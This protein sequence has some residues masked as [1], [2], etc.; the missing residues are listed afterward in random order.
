[1][2]H[3][4][5][6]ATIFRF[7]GYGGLSRT[8]ETTQ[9]VTRPNPSQTGTSETESRYREKLSRSDVS[10]IGYLDGSQ[11]VWIAADSRVDATVRVLETALAGVLRIRGT[12]PKYLFSTVTI[13]PEPVL[14]EVE[15]E[16][17]RKRIKLLQIENID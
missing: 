16:R 3:L 9:S 12:G 17:N 14:G 5:E 7:T 13:V 15:L 1:M 8:F 10:F 6:G 11:A 4:E 2:A